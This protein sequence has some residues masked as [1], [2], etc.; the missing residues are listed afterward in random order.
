MNQLDAWRFVYNNTKK[1]ETK[2]IAK[3]HIER[4]EKEK[5]QAETASA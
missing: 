2:R 4:I 3:R 5:A 1:G